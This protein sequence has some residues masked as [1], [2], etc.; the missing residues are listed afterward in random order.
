[1]QENVASPQLKIT[2]S[3]SNAQQHW[4]HWNEL[5]LLFLL[6]KE[7]MLKKGLAW[8]YTTY[9]HRMELS[10][11]TSTLVPLYSTWQNGLLHSTWLTRACFGHFISKNSRFVIDV[12]FQWENQAKTRRTGLW[13][14]SNPEKPW[15]W[16]KNK[17]TGTVW[18]SSGFLFQ[19][20]TR[21]LLIYRS[22]LL[23]RR[24]KVQKQ[25]FHRFRV[26]YLYTCKL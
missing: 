25:W 15:E 20:A 16:R 3:G 10:K 23:P 19:A 13:A 24:P 1:M 14:L 11:V 6:Q 4:G 22:E 2:C 7:H 26:C 18:S 9:D 5:L 17:R 21:C 12:N 8:H